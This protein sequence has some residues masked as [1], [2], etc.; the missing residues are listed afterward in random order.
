MRVSEER[1]SEESGTIHDWDIH[2]TRDSED[3]R[4]L[5]TALQ[6]RAIRMS[7]S[8]EF[9]IASLAQS[10]GIPIPA[11]RRPIAKKTVLAAALPALWLTDSPLLRT[12]LPS[13]TEGIVMVMEQLGETGYVRLQEKREERREEKR[14]EKRE[15]KNE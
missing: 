4:L 10:E 1:I 2:I 8:A 9:L 3:N 14:R 11:S 6:G 5:I 13:G 12:I 15:E 7:D